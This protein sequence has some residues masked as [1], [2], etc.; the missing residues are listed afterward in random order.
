MTQHEFET[1]VLRLWATTRIPLTRVNLQL[2]TDTPRD[3]IA[4]WMD[5]LV[6]AGIAEVDS[7]D[8]GEVVWRI[9]GAERSKSGPRT[10]DDWARLQ[11]LLREIDAADVAPPPA[12][13]RALAR[14]SPSVAHHDEKSLL[15]SGLLS[16]VFGPF[17]WLYAA[18]LKD[19]G[20]GVLVVMVVSAVL[21]ATL[22]ASFL[23]M[24]APLSALAGLVYAQQYNA[25]GCRRSLADLFAVVRR[26]PPGHR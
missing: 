16:F 4:R 18:P 24:F 9:R 26:L 7:D 3:R 17:G 25:T 8:E 15:A 6:L 20:V 2:Y 1:A 12:S 22:A 11:R 14:V 19:V 5:D 21:P 23:G 13:P 10:I